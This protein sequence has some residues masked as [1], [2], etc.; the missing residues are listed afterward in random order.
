L[1]SHVGARTNAT[2]FR[3]AAKDDLLALIVAD[4]GKEDLERAPLALTSRPHVAAVNAER[5]SFRRLGPDPG[6]GFP[7]QPGANTKGSLPGHC[8]GLRLIE[9]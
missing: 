3:Y 2:A 6:D 5:D 8:H 1:I 7:L 9:R 4:L